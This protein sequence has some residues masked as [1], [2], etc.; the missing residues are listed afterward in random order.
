MLI[1]YRIFINTVFLILP[2]IIIVR[3]LKGKE[4]YRRVKEKI[5]FNSIKRGTGNLIWFHGASVGEMKSIIPLIAK[6]EK[7]KNIQ[8]ILITSNT[9]SSAKIFKNLKLKKTI[10]QFFPI[11]TNFISKKFINYWSPSKV[12][13]VD[14][15]IWPNMILNIKQKKI[16]LILINGRI[17]KKSFK[18]W[19]R[20]KN[21]SKE[22]FSNFDLCLTSNKIS[23]N[24]LTKL[25]AKNI[26]YLGNL[27]FTES[28]NKKAHLNEKLNKFLNS[29]NTWCA[30]S[31]HDNEEIISGLV[32]LR[33]KKKL[34]NL[35]TI[36]IPRH[37]ERSNQI[38]IDLEQLGLK[39]F[40]HSNKKKIGS[41][42]DIYLVNAYDQTKLFFNKCKNVFLGGS[43]IN[44][45]GQNP[46]EAARY[47]CNI[48]HGPNIQ[49]FDEIYQF[50]KEKN[51]SHKVKNINEFY[52]VLSKLLTS[53]YRY[54][55]IKTNINILGEN[56]LNKTLKKINAV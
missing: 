23:K 49:N 31:T 35:L 9:I 16:P 5:G 33:L 45:G 56:I 20:F 17:T 6:L 24:Y 36:I 44:R 2:I 26:N 48:L 53:K 27:K 55:K 11:D 32:H 13:F 43:L 25:K 42:S 22:I 51:V 19:N 3:L 10:H 47:G 41:N 12:F 38:K 14:S 4:D 18:R 39:V 1:I 40:L 21:F 8:K 46:L 37:I 34:R 28:K 15:E 54:N 29:K 7:Q 52:K 50:L 30:S